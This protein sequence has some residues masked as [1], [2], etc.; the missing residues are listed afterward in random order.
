MSYSTT[1][2]ISSLVEDVKHE[3][4]ARF[5]LRVVTSR[6]SAVS[7]WKAGRKHDRQRV[8]PIPK[9]NPNP[10]S[11]GQECPTHTG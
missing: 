7:I 10:N 1:I 11:V 3:M 8:L 6:L 9:T 2:M 4:S 5:Q